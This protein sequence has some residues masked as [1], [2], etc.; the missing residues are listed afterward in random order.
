MDHSYG[1]TRLKIRDACAGVHTGQ[2]LGHLCIAHHF[3]V[4]ILG[5]LAEIW[6]PPKNWSPRIGCRNWI[7]RYMIYV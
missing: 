5:K 7:A 1:S 4:D 3:A 2:L 6:S